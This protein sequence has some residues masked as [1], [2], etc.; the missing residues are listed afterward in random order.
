MHR[1]SLVILLILHLSAVPFAF[2]E[3]R[4]ERAT[5]AE[6][7]AHQ[8]LSLPSTRLVVLKGVVL[9]VPALLLLPLWP[10]GR[11][12]G[13]SW[14]WLVVGVVTIICAARLKRSAVLALGRLHRLDLGIAPGHRIIDAG[15]Y[16]CIRHP[17]YA[18][19]AL[20]AVG[21]GIGRASW[22]SAAVMTCAFAG[23]LAL[24]IRTEE[25][26]LD[27]VLAQQYAAYRAR[28]PWR[29]VPHLW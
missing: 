5:R 9:L 6:R 19:T 22:A 28:T 14:F 11:L 8:V 15:P 1:Q 12:P 24:R 18:A 29:L 3:A 7:P 17:S 16:R 21:L 27:A 10:A 2:A 23:G 4:A 13:P 25:Q 26:A 20:A